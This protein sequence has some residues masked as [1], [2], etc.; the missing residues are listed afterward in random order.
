VLLGVGL[1]RPLVEDAELLRFVDEGPRFEFSK[2]DQSISLLPASVVGG[3]DWGQL[4]PTLCAPQ[5]LKRDPDGSYS[6]A[7]IRT[8]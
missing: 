8:G 1:Q 6:R 5:P 2:L 7:Y 3:R 4:V